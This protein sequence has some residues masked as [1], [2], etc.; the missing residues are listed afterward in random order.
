[1]S[2]FRIY[3]AGLAILV[4]AVGL[5]LLAAQIGLATWYSFLSLL[6]E[7]GLLPALSSLKPFDYFFLFLLYPGLLGLAA[8]LTLKISPAGS[9]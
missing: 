5:N 8:F 6:P 9:S 2:L 3:L 1:M 7:A 4:A